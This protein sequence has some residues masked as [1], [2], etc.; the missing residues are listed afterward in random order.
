MNKQ[1][2]SFIIAGLSTRRSLYIYQA[3]S[4]QTRNLFR[5][6]NPIWPIDSKKNISSLNPTLHDYQTRIINSRY[7]YIYSK[8]NKLFTSDS[9]LFLHVAL[10][11]LSFSDLWA[12]FFFVKMSNVRIYSYALFSFIRKCKMQRYFIPAY[13]YLQQ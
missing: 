10:F 7:L 3:L 1:I 5:E 11:M 8:E 6:K 12:V 9:L 13:Q 4:K 2:E